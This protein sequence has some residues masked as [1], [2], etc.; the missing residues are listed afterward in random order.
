MARILVVDDEPG[1]CRLLES[2]FSELG[3]DSVTVGTVAD[4][5]KQS[6]SQ[7]FDVVF[8]DVRLPDGNG[9]EALPI[10][11]DGPGAPEVIIMTGYGDPDGAELAVKNGAWDYLEKPPSMDQF[12]L[13]LRRSL[14]YRHSKQNSQALRV[15]DRVGVIGESRSIKE[16]LNLAAEAAATDANVLIA[17]ETG[18]G[19]ELFA[20]VLH[21]NSARANEPF[22]VVDCASLP[23]NLVESVLFGHEKGAFTGADRARSGLLQQADKGTLF[24]DEVGELPLFMQKKLLRALQEHSFRPVGGA[25]EKRSDFRLLAATNRDL[26]EMVDNGRFRDDL[27]FRLKT[28]AIKLPPLRDRLDDIEDLV[29]HFSNRLCNKYQIPL[30]GFSPDFFDLLR[31]YGWPGNVRELFNT[32]EMVLSRCI[33]EP[34]LFGQHLPVELR[35]KG[36][37]STIGQRASGKPAP[38]VVSG[39]GSFDKLLDQ[40]EDLPSFK[41]FRDN[42]VDMLERH[43][44]EKLLLETGND[45][46]EAMRIS[47]LAKT[48]LYGLLKK[49]DLAFI[50]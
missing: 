38:A 5:L 24:L 46:N 43:Y 50:K 11:R 20:K 25:S 28:F 40:D 1:I 47:G 44:L 33:D 18:T 48:R 49:H 27:L 26:Q 34:V 15:L 31:T 17:G 19:K 42:C 4:A 30:K 16:C 41:D 23:E 35:A 45:R 32:L 8:L 2:E 9:L 14:E 10:L 39:D 36:I 21:S 6:G 12:S 29:V 7:E 22:V 13:A 37:R 3:H